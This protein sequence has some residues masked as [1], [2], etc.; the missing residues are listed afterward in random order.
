MGDL[1]GTF[2]ALGAFAILCAMLVRKAL[3]KLEL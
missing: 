3:Q 1:P 2:V